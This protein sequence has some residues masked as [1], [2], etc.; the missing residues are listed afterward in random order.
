MQSIGD[1]MARGFG[2]FG[3]LAI[4]RFRTKISN[5]RNISFIFAAMAVGIACGVYSFMNA[6]IGT[7]AFCAIAFLL[8]LTPFSR[9]SKLVGSLRFQLPAGSDT[10]QVVEAVLKKACKSWVMKRYRVQLNA[11]NE[12]LIE[13]T[14]DV[15]LRKELDGAELARE[16]RPLP[17]I[18]DIRLNFTDIYSSQN[19]Y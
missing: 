16:I 12:E 17:G 4:L 13:Y 11:E 3:A 2:I 7:I 19:E 10:L 6:I 8:S 15:R 18:K 14:Y 5:P 9:K 1:S